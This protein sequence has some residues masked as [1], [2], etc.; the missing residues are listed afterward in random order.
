MVRVEIFMVMMLMDVVFVVEK[1]IIILF[2]FVVKWLGE[3][4]RDKL[5][6]N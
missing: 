4:I 6:M 5:E 3:Y 1:M 2:N